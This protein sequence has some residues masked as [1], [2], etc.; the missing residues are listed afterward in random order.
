M[1][2]IYYE[3]QIA[4]N[5]RKYQSKGTYFDR[6]LADSDYEAIVKGKYPRMHVKRLVI[7]SGSIVKVLRKDLL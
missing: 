7:H 1:T 6:D 2:D 5:K 4:G 3:I